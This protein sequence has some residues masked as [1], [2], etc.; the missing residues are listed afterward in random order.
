MC[1]TR[2]SQ[3]SLQQS[4]VNVVPDLWTFACAMYEKPDVQASCHRLQNHYNLDIPL[5]LF[6]FWLGAYHDWDQQNLDKCL[7]EVLAFTQSYAAQTVYPLRAIRCAM[8]QAYNPSWPL[9]DIQWQALREQVKALELRSER[10]QS[11]GLARVCQAYS[12]SQFAVH[13]QIINKR[14]AIDYALGFCFPEL[15]AD[16]QQ[17][18]Y[19]HSFFTEFPSL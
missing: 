9:S 6:C 4:S 11:I 2:L 15:F 5:L 13:G 3:Q 7:A 1:Q 16:R 18:D 14:K 17:T 19:L 10:E 12:S 8:K